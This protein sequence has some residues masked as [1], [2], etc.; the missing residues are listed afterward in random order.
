MS[1][2]TKCGHCERWIGMGQPILWDVDD[3][4]NMVYF[5]CRACHLEWQKKASRWLRRSSDHA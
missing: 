3:D 5:C 4:G 2:S 1:D